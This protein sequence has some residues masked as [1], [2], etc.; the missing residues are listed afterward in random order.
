MI[1][2]HVALKFAFVCVSVFLSQTA[3]AQESRDGVDSDGDL[4]S[5]A[6]PVSPLEPFVDCVS[7]NSDGT[8]TA[9]FGYQNSGAAT[10]TI[11]AGSNSPQ[12]GVNAFTPA[13][14]DQGQVSVF[15]PGKVNGAFG[16]V[17]DGSR[18]TW[19]LQ[20]PGA[21]VKTV[22]AKKDVSRQCA[23]LKPVVECIDQKA[24]GTYVAHFGYKNDNSFEIE[25]PTGAL[26][27]FVPA[28]EDR[29]QPDLF[30]TGR[31]TNL[32]SVNFDGSAL[33]WILGGESATA[34]R[35]SALCSPNSLPVCHAGGPYS[36]ACQGAQTTVALSAT[37]SNDPEGQSLTYKWTSSCT[38]ATISDATAESPTL[39]VI[40]PDDGAAVACTVELKVSDGI[41]SV[42]CEQPVA[43]GACET[44]CDG[45]T[46]GSAVTDECGVCGGDG[47]TC[48]DCNGVPNGGAVEDQCGI[49]GGT[50][51]CL[52]CLGIPDGTAKP[53]SCG[54]CGGDGSTCLGCTDTD[55]TSM[56]FAMDTDAQRQEANI[57]QFARRLERLDSSE[58]TERFIAQTRLEADKLS[59]RNWQLTWSLPQIIKNCTDTQ[60]CS[61]VDNSATVNSYNTNAQTMRDLSSEVFR[62]INRFLNGDVRLNDRKLDKGAERI[63]QEAIGISSS[64]PRFSSVC[65]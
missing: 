18:L 56:L 16:V 55:I 6:G 17:F 40:A 45:N 5:G 23:P 53:D 36:A 15:Q 39:T 49:C 63:Y 46:G 48:L 14:S 50:N 59:T 35:Y 62:R 60:T 4:I 52:D 43:V 2:T 64:V 30:F 8:F 19:T 24:G 3:A 58:S 47:S 61:Q 9:H 22:T 27:K 38:G 26:N 11:P 7:P 29:G 21:A 25:I 34:D 20:A 1:D 28:P 10:V 32:F 41:D 51:A 57:I 65:Q 42:S 54:V 44:D 37:G 33:K 12:S 13:P 31:V